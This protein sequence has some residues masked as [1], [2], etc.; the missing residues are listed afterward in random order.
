M[1]QIHERLAKFFADNQ[2]SQKEVAERMGTSRAYINALL[3][4]RTRI[5]K[6]QAEKMSNLFHLSKGWLLTGE[7]DMMIGDSEP[8]QVGEA[9]KSYNVVQMYNPGQES[10]N[11][12]TALGA[13]TAAHGII[14]K[15]QEQM[16]R[17]IT[18]IEK[19]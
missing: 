13:V 2:L 14:E 3:V 8:T 17:L 11:L 5:G 1:E 12:T 10:D 19:K 6:K 18:L 7:G 9:S 16:D 15:M 4:G